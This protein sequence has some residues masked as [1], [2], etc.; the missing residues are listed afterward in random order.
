MNIKCNL[1]KAALVLGCTVPLAIATPALAYT[2]LAQHHSDGPTP[3]TGCLD[4]HTSTDAGEDTTA[5]TTPTGGAN[6]APRTGE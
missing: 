5:R 2:Q 1:V 3:A 6:D 4:P